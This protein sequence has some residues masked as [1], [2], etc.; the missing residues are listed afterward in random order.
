ME[1]ITECVSLAYNTG[2]FDTP[3]IAPVHKLEDSLHV[4][5]LW[6]GPTSAFKDLA[7]QIMPLLLTRAAAKTGEEAAI[8]ILV[9]TSGDT[10]RPLWKALKTSRVPE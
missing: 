1:E 6:H 2:R 4:L 10:G 3:E 7:L 9:A 8:V 5:E